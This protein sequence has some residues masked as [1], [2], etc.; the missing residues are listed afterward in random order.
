MIAIT[1]ASGLLGSFIV[2]Q[3]IS[4]GEQVI[5]L[6]RKNSDTSSLKHIQ[7]KIQWRVADLLD[8]ISLSESLNGVHTVIH[9]AALVSFNPRKAKIIFDTNVT[10]TKN[11]VKRCE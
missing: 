1:G 7:E 6:T 10:G 5:A 3:F 2:S 8:P 9:T 11:V 4:E